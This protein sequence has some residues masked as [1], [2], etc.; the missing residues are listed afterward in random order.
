[1]K[2]EIINIKASLSKHSQLY[3]AG[4]ACLLALTLTVGCFSKQSLV[5]YRSVTEKHFLWPSQPP[6][7]CPFEKSDIILGIG[8]T[9]RSKT[10]GGSDTWY[11]TW[12]SDGH[13][14]SP[15]TDGSINGVGASSH[16][17][18]ATTGQAKI[19]G[20]DPLN[21]KIIPLGAT[22]GP[23]TPYGGRY[24]CGSL[25][26]NGVWYYGTYCLEL[27]DIPGYTKRFGGHT[28]ALPD[29][30]QRI[31]QIN[32][33]KMDKNEVVLSYN[34][35]RLGPFVGFRYSTDYGKTW[36]DTPHSPYKPIFNEPLKKGGS[37]K[38]GAPHFVDFGKNME[39]SPDGKAYLV[40]H[41][42]SDPDPKPRP[43]NASWI[44]GDQVYLLRVEPSI[45][46]INDPSKYEFFAGHDAGGNPVWTREL[47]RIKP[48]VDWN[49]RCGCVT[50]TY[51][52]PLK[53]YLMCVTDG[54]PTTR[55][56]NTYVLESD[57]VTG[58]WKLVTFM[59]EFGV[60]A[61]F[62]NFPSKFISPDGRSA[63]LCYSNNFGNNWFCHALKKNPPGAR[64]A[65][66]LQEVKLLDA[67]TYRKYEKN[68][69]P[70]NDHGVKIK[71]NDAVKKLINSDAN[72][73]RKA[74]VTS[75]TQ[76][77]DNRNPKYF[78]PQ[79]TVDGIVNG[80]PD[81]LLAEWA[82]DGEKEGAML[83]L[84]WDSPQQIDRVWLF[85]RPIIGEQITSGLLLFSDGSSVKVDEL[86]DDISGAREIRFP[87]KTVEW[88][89]FVVTSVSPNTQNIGLSEISVFGPK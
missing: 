19:I 50:M 43:G 62:V 32:A 76:Y 78:H 69:Q 24:P 35:P 86:P 10:Y 29:I 21:L 58:P 51:N 17:A 22:P 49:N 33:G 73:A 87:V 88:L 66:S 8:F 68:Y 2:D 59:F 11:P 42:A 44:S 28:V 36:T 75:T 81:N 23:S 31:Q 65:L 83:R 16:G 60:Q 63:W 47:A 56:M 18:K 46:N 74:K 25:V 55:E 3:V 41:G 39:H 27:E 52:A 45:E 57:A 79:A 1:M 64:Y 89:M 13:L 30:V 37:V 71:E 70:Q 54:W 7:D 6:A 80:Y 15:F 5:P 26:H 48:L 40:A 9:G 72:L 61:Y 53:K 14:Y 4:F 77:T 20:E 12:G 67:K 34:W 84:T 82:S 85:D 38:I